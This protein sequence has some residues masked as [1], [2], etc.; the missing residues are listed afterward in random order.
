[1]S[2]KL[3]TYCAFIDF[4]KAFDYINR[5]ILLYKLFGYNIDGR[6]FKTINGLYNESRSCIKINN[7]YTYFFNVEF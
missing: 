6:V 5:E 4:K 2:N 1:M 7:I 3:S